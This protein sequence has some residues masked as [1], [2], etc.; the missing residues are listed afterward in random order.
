MEKAVVKSVEQNSIAF[1]C[2]IEP[3]DVILSIDDKPIRDILDFKYYIY[4][5]T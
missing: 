2:G 4:S 1:D 3:G 5:G